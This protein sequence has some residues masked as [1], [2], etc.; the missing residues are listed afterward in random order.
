M[1][2]FDR[3]LLTSSVSACYFVVMFIRLVSV[4][5]TCLSQLR[6][7]SWLPSG[8]PLVTVSKTTIIYDISSLVTVYLVTVYLVTVYLATIYLVTVYLVTVSLATVYLV[9]VSLVTV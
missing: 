3:I 6:Q 8:I 9:T 4:I 1:G 2:V 5:I 7:V